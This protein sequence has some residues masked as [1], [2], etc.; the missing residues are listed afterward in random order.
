MARRRTEVSVL[1]LNKIIKGRV[2]ANFWVAKGG[3]EA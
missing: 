1:R 3:T 2:V